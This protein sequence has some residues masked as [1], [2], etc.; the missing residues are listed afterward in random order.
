MTETEKSPL[1][2]LEMLQHA[3]PTVDVYDDVLNNLLKIGSI[4]SQAAR[5]LHYLYAS[6]P[7]LGALA[8]ISIAQSSEAAPNRKIKQA[9]AGLTGHFA[10]PPVA[11]VVL[12]G[13]PHH[14]YPINLALCKGFKSLMVKHLHGIQFFY[15][16]AQED[17]LWLFEREDQRLDVW[18]ALL[19]LKVKGGQF[20]GN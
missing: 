10:V 14:N 2:E 16:M 19:N 12:N 7:E 15:G 4:D 9:E 11:F 5:A 8:G 1:A 18:C 13:E 3:L 17:I 6:I 20:D